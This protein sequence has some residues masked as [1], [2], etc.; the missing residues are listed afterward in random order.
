MAN[1]KYIDE[2]L[3][4]DAPEDESSNKVT[5]KPYSFRCDERLLEDMT[6]YAD[7]EGITLPQ[8][9]SRIMTDFLENKTLTNTYL[10]EYEGQYI[11]IPSNVDES[12]S[13]DYEL[14]YVVNN[15]DV[16]WSIYGY[17]AKEGTYAGKIHEGIDFVVIP[18]TVHLSK[19][20]DAEVIPYHIKCE[21]IPSCLYCIYITV[22]TA[23]EVEYEVISWIDAMNKL[24]A[25]ERYDL[26]SHANTIKKRLSKLYDDYLDAVN[27]TDD[28]DMIHYTIYGKLLKIAKDFNTGAIIPAAESID[29]I[30]Y[31]PIVEH[32]PDNYQLMKENDKLKKQ[33]S[34]VDEVLEIFDQMEAVAKRL[35]E[36]ERR[37]NDPEYREEAWQ[38][39]IND[40]N[41][42]DEISDDNVDELPTDELVVERTLDD[43]TTE[44]ITLQGSNDDLPE[45]D[46]E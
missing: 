10:P 26:I 24:K 5:K 36:L 27:I 8:L 13:Y 9:L 4:P 29:N 11:S 22:D 32:L 42:Q 45:S 38:E 6:T 3:L 17:A 44:E 12:K 39:F 20:P 15:L 31:A 30:E 28:Y 16:W 23:G 21:N 35:D 7:K 18:E 33:L 37:S 1:P 40:G 25:V 43:G 14:R 19:N 41:N 34:K 2:S 46:D